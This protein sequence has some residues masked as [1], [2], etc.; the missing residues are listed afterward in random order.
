MKLAAIDTSTTLGSVAL[1]DDGVLVAEDTR[2][3]SNAHGESL[4][5]MMDALFARLGW[6]PRDIGRWAVGI[7]PGS[8]T[9]VRIGVA[10]VKGIVIATSAEIVGVTSLDTLAYGLHPDEGVSCVTVLFAMKGELFLQATLGGEIRFGPVNV[11][12]E[13][14]PALLSTLRC[15]RIL[16]AGDGTRW[17]DTSVVE[18]PCEVHATPPY[19]V[20]RASSLGAIA[21]GRAPDDPMR[22]EPL[23]V[24]APD[25]T[26][27]RPSR[28][29]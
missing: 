16:L 9:G 28:P 5:P 1:F 7:G 4:L 29:A 21:M 8:F 14:A 23:Y 20:P 11:R 26:S 27:P 22:L 17:I 3:V 2:R 19:D 15:E 25:V 13:D 18:T 12:I 24:R 10:T 6:R